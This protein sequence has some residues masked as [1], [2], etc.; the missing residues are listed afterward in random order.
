M[1]LLYIAVFVVLPACGTTTF[2]ARHSV[3]PVLLG[4]VLSLGG[5]A[6]SPGPST[7]RFSSK[8]SD[9]S[10][11]YVVVSK[12]KREKTDAAAV[13][14]SSE[15][16]SSDQNDFDVLVATAGDPSARVA[17]EGLTCGGYNLNVFYTYYINDAWC[18]SSGSVRSPSPEPVASV[19]APSATSTEP[20][21]PA[22]TPSAES[23]AEPPTMP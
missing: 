4:P 8:S 6:G 2:S 18:E 1:K 10:E 12:D 9:H 21:A 16:T 20:P 11:V 15:S 5:V 13:A 23:S 19:A 17:L 14:S 22:A 7:N 3:N